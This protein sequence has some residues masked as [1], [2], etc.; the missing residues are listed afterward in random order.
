LVVSELV[1]NVIRHTSGI[2]T[3]RLMRDRTLTVEVS[4]E[5][6]TSP[7]LRHARAQDEDGR[8]LLIVASL[9]QRWGTRYTSNGKIIWVEESL[10]EDE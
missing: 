8:G 6:T 10:D 2:P 4:D 1:T 3:V 7:H 9:A 5:A